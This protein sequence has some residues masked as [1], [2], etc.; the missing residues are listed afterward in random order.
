MVA[1]FI[2]VIFLAKLIVAQQNPLK[3]NRGMDFY[4]DVVDWVGGYP[5]EYA[6]VDEMKALL[7]KVGAELKRLVPAQVPTGCNEYVCRVE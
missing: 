2:P 1:V 6:S 7:E 5:Y 4:H 3:M